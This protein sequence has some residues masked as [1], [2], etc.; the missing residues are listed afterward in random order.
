MGVQHPGYQCI[1]S[2]QQLDMRKVHNS[3]HE[4]KIFPDDEG[5]NETNQS[6]G[7]CKGSPRFWLSSSTLDGLS[8]LALQEDPD[9]SK[10]II[11]NVKAGR[12]FPQV[13]RFGHSF[14]LEL[15]AASSAVEWTLLPLAPATKCSNALKGERKMCGEPMSGPDCGVSRG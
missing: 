14:S 5:N 3:M 9:L 7:V 2:N 6:G 8:I 11:S 12:A 10:I 4:S 1:P 15:T 13:K